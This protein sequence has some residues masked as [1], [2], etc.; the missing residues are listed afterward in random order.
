MEIRFATKDDIETM[1]DIRTKQLHDQENQDHISKVD[2]EEY[3][4]YLRDYLNKLFM[5]NRIF[6]V[7]ISV[8]NEIVATGA[9][10]LMDLPPS[11]SN[12]SGHVGYITN[13]YTEPHHRKNGYASLVL[14]H[15]KETGDKLKIKR[16]IL[17]S[18]ISGRSVYKRFGFQEIDWYKYDLY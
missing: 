14:K 1:I 8:K 6:Q 15:L 17:G 18:T 13:M 2:I 5:E 3:K 10:I 7:I 12:L 11:F 9:L 4:L 16:L